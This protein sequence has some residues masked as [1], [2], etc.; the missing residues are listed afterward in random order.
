M[1]R[2]AITAIGTNAPCTAASV[3]EVL[4]N[5]DCDIGDSIMTILDNVCVMTLIITLPKRKRLSLIIK[6]LNNLQESNLTA[7]NIDE[8]TE[9]RYRAGRRAS[10]FIFTL[11]G[12]DRPGIIPDTCALL[13][14]LKVNINWLESMLVEGDKARLCILVAEG[15]TPEKASINEV[16]AELKALAKK[17]EMTPE[18]TSIGPTQEDLP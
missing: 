7:I 2:Y 13:C 10:N 8:L 6:D 3:T 17:L 15:T 4:H 16:G 5:H 18:I 1:R 14:R 9:P 12:K 11:R